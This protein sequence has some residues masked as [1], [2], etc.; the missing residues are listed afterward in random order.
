MS[1]KIDGA[2]YLLNSLENITIDVEEYT[3]VSPRISETERY[4]K[5]LKLEDADQLVPDYLRISEA[6]RN[7]QNNQ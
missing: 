4:E 5:A 3:H 1:A 7:W 2:V 6:E